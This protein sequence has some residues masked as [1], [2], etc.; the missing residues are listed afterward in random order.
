MGLRARAQDGT[1]GLDQATTTVHSY[2]DSG[3]KLMYAVCGLVALIGAVHVY[4]KWSR[5]DHDTKQ[6]AAAWIGACI[7]LVTVT[8]IIKSFFAL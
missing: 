2:F 5:G 7:F 8:I 6:V 4:T 1:T 3:A